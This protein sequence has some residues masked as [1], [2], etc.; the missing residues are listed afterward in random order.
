MAQPFHPLGDRLNFLVAGKGIEPFSP[1]YEAGVLPVYLPTKG[2]GLISCVDHPGGYQYSYISRFLITG[3]SLF[4]LSAW[5]CFDLS[6]LR[7][8]LLNHEGTLQRTHFFQCGTTRPETLI[9]F[10]LGYLYVLLI[11]KKPPVRI[12]GYNFL[13]VSTSLSIDFRFVKWLFTIAQPQTSS[14]HLA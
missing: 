1:A 3:I 7:L 14:I 9:M 12:A 6:S 2:Q 8:S 11:T 10:F 5:F 13:H 4:S